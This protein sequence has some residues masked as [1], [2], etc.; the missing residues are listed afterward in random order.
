MNVRSDMRLTHLMVALLLA[1]VA[2]TGCGGGGGSGAA[3]NNFT[4]TVSGF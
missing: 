3:G 4:V 2:L 1:A